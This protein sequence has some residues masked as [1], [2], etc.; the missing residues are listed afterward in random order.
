MAVTRAAEDLLEALSN[1]Y[2]RRSR[3]R[4]WRPR[5]ADD[6]DK[7]AAY[8]TLHEVL[9][10]LC[11][12]LAPVV[13]FITEK[14]YAHLVRDADAA[15]PA[16]VHLCDYP[17]PDDAL[18]DEPLVREMDAAMRVVSQ[19][20]TLRESRQTAGSPAARPDGGRPG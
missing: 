2:V 1:W 18:Y 10:L 11:K 12:A 8:Q 9:V 14:F 19:A 4:F 7:L 16:S 5:S 3:R 17:Q 20:L 6:G 13:P 15:A